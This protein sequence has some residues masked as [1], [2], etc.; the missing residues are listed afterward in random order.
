MSFPNADYFSAPAPER[1]LLI[2]RLRSGHE[3]PEVW[4]RLFEQLKRNREICDEVWFSTGTAFP[5][6]DEHRRKSELF[7]AYAEQLRSIGIIPS[8]QLQ[9]TLGHGDRTFADNSLEGKNWGSYIG[10]NGEVTRSC[11]CPNHPSSGKPFRWKT[12][13]RRKF[14]DSV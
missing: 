5:K 3:E 10:R 11:N 7:A 6:M 14:P 2:I 9:A 8:L 1:P 4:K 13:L 12:T